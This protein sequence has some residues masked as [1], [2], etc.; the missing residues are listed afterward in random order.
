MINFFKKEKKAIWWSIE[1]QLENIAPI[2]PLNKFIPNWFQSIKST[3]SDAF[4]RGGTVKDCPSFLDLFS[5]GY[6][7]PLWCDL[8]LTVDNCSYKWK[9][10]YKGFE[11]TSH[12]SSQFK[13]FL[14][15]DAKENTR[16]ILKA[17]CPWRLKT[18]DGYSTWQFPM[19]YHY[20]PVFEVL[21]GIIRT[22]IHHEINQ[23]MVIKKDGEHK[24]P[25][26]TPLAIY[27]PFKREKLPYEIRNCNDKEVRQWT[28]FNY[29][30]LISKFRRSYLNIH[31]LKTEKGKC[32]FL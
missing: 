12:P 20:N 23:Q 25:R 1:D 17:E 26:G 11:F 32:P 9:T 22:D 5:N 2:V 28:T 29:L 27:V 15:E 13:D 6:V 7:V 24:I 30:A 4:F 31:K 10:P 3:P 16:L 8:L 19:F 14:P 18:P 21:P